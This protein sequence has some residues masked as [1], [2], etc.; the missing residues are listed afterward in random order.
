MNEMIFIPGIPVAQGRPRFFRR[1]DKVGCYDPERSKRWKAEVAQ[2]ARLKRVKQAE[3]ALAVGMTFYLPVPKSLKKKREGQPHTVKPDVS[4][5]AKLVEDALNGIAWRDDSEIA[6]LVLEKRY[7]GRGQE[8]GVCV[9]FGGYEY[10]DRNNRR[11]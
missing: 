10:N 8:T 9:T 3:G 1:G 5:L 11:A 7:A 4:N 2:I 6:L